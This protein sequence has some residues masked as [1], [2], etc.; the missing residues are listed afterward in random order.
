MA[1]N[2]NVKKKEKQSSTDLLKKFQKLAKSSGVVA[3]LKSKK[4]H[5]RAMSDF[6]KKAAALKRLE[7]KAIAER[8]EKLGKKK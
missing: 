4:F 7:R 5:E 2:V 6:K 8:L 3:R 1:L